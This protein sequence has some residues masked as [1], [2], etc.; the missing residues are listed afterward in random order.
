MTPFVTSQD[1]SFCFASQTATNQI[2]RQVQEVFIS[3]SKELSVNHEM[4]SVSVASA[5]G[6]VMLS[7]ALSTA[8]RH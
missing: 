5:S 3:L 7:C 8:A 2:A 1:F 6:Q 4:L